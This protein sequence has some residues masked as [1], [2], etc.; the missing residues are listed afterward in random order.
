MGWVSRRSGSTKDFVIF[1]ASLNRQRQC[2]FKYFESKKTTRGRH[3]AETWNEE[4]TG[5][6]LTFSGRSAQANNRPPHCARIEK[7]WH[8]KSHTNRQ[9]I[10]SKIIQPVNLNIRNTASTFK[11]YSV[12]IV[13]H[14]GS[15][16]YSQKSVILDNIQMKQK[17]CM[18]SRDLERPNILCQ[19]TLYIYL[20][21]TSCIKA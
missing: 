14:G 11:P 5:L 2:V 8:I 3:T 17:L 12:H 15:E 20:R 10:K 4:N 18:I 13:Y 16:K 21:Q 19:G 9:Q 6:L 1:A 7:C